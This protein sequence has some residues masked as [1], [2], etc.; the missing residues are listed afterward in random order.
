VV[1]GAIFCNEDILAMAS[2]TTKPQA[3]GSVA[4]DEST[5]EQGNNYP[6]FE[7]TLSSVL[8]DPALIVRTSI[9]SSAACSSMA[10]IASNTDQEHEFCYASN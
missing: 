3:V 9:A 2:S 10:T 7:N 1:L 4:A 5:S 6:V 8:N